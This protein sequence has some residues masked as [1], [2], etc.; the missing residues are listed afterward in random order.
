MTSVFVR[1]W[2]LVDLPAIRTLIWRSWLAT[3]SGFIPRQDLRVYLD[4]HYTLKALQALF[5]DEHV[6]GFVVEQEGILCGYARTRIHLEMERFHLA[7]LYLLPECEGRGLGGLLL[8]EILNEAGRRGFDSLWLGVM[9][10]N[11]RALAWYRKQGCDF[12]VSM[13]FTMGG[14][15]VEHL[16]GCLKIDKR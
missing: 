2:Q 4:E 14:T 8:Q 13:P 9:V 16:I 15:T 11:A 6:S 1:P 5:A 12:F 7:S 10:Q 3:Y